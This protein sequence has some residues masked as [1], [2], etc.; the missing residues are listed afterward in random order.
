M[1]RHVGGHTD[2]DTGRSVDQ[3]LRDAGRHDRGFLER[4]VEV[5]HHVD[6]I[7]VD[8]HHQV[9]GDLAQ[10]GL[11]V[12]H[13]GGRVAVH[14]AEVTLA[15]HQHI[16]QRPRLGHTHHRFIHRAV[17]VRVV[18]T[19]HLAHDTG[20]LFITRRRG[21]T[22]FVHAVKHAAV[23]RFEPVAH[24]GKCAGN[25]HRHRIV[26]VRGFHLVDY[27]DGYQ[28]FSIFH[29]FSQ[30]FLLLFFLH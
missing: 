2:G 3:Q 25:D 15:V 19:Q 22:Q 6:R 9:F 12:T 14:A 11:G 17:A 10:A 23:Y 5:G 24:I 16:A 30:L 18:F 13:R 7:L 29:N 4:I 26:D 27:V 8:V 20:R 21:D 1:R 28:F